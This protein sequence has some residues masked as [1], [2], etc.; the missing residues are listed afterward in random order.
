MLFRSGDLEALIAYLYGECDPEQRR[1][2]SAHV[3]V[4]QRCAEEL[5][6]LDSTREQL[7]QWVPPEVPLGFRMVSQAEAP[8]AA[9]V[10][11]PRQ[12]W[13]QPLPAWAQAAA[14]AGA[15]QRRAADITSYLAEP[16]PPVYQ[17]KYRPLPTPPKAQFRDPIEA[18]GSP[19]AGLAMIAGLFTRTAGTTDDANTDTTLMVPA[20]APAVGTGFDSTIDNVLDL[21]SRLDSDG[22]PRKL[23]RSFV[24]VS[25]WLGRD[26]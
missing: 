23:V 16:R 20:T 15:A 4:C 13:G 8:Q 19:I 21:V 3:A 10:L 1:V 22:R 12:W 24:A 7:V 2:V 25:G 6:A 17:P 11:K 18:V 26:D 14:A 5:M 9:R